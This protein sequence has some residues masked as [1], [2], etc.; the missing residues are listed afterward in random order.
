MDVLYSPQDLPCELPGRLRWKHRVHKSG[1][2][3]CARECAP[4]L[5]YAYLPLNIVT[6]GFAAHLCSSMHVHWRFPFPH[7]SGKAM[8][9]SRIHR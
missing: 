2:D 6:E 5:F 3:F 4:Y 7:L 9:A 1:T 8:L